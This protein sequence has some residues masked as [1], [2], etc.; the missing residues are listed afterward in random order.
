MKKKT[1]LCMVL[2]AVMVLAVFLGLSACTREWCIPPDGV[3]CCEELQAQ[4]NMDWLDGYHGYPD[5]EVPAVDETDNYVIVNGDRIAALWGSDPGSIKVS[6][7]CQEPNHPD[8]DLGET[9]YYLEFVKRTETEC[10][11]KDDAGNLYTFV[12]VDDSPSDD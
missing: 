12:R 7:F 6:I 8:F 10:V 3:W 4:F 5:E 2:V 9:I 11:L 1:V